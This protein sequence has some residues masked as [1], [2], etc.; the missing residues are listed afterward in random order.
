MAGQIVPQNFKVPAGTEESC[1]RA[2]FSFVPDGTLGWPCA[3]TPAMNGWAIFKAFFPFTCEAGGP[4]KKTSE[5]VSQKIFDELPGPGGEG[6]M[7]NEI[8]RNGNAI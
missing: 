7:K 1:E 2:A 5:T 4:G 6:G 3:S 8:G